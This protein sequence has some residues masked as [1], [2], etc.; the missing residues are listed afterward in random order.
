[1]PHASELPTLDTIDNVLGCMYVLEGATL[2]GQL[3]SR[4]L[5]ETQD[6]TSLDAGRFFAGYGDRTA[7]MWRAFGAAVT[8]HVDAG[9]DAD[10]IVSGA[11]ATFQ[12]FGQWIAGGEG[13]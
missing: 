1:M 7:S 13:E 3:I 8:A 5:R 11:R 12:T 10:R 2:G 4:H 9:G 6:I